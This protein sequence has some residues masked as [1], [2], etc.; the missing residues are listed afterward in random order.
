MPYNQDPIADFDI[1]HTELRL[2][3]LE[4]VNGVI[5]SINKLKNRGLKKDQIEELECAERIKAWLEEGKDVR[6]GAQG[7]PGRGR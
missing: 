2:K 4:R 6:C 3:D 7:L 1:I 5:D